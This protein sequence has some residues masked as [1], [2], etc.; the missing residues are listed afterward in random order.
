MYKYP[1][2]FTDMRS[3]LNA[4]V[5]NNFNSFVLFSQC[6]QVTEGGLQWLFVLKWT[7]GCR[8]L[9]DSY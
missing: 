4:N 7:H 5:N 8:E 6:N 3:V 1:R 9:T 2:T